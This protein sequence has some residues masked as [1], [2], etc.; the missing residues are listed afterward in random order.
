MLLE[1][2]VLCLFIGIIQRMQQFHRQ[3][4]NQE[5]LD[6]DLVVCK[7]VVNGSFCTLRNVYVVS[8]CKKSLRVNCEHIC[9]GLFYIE[10]RRSFWTVY[11]C[12]HLQIILQIVV[13]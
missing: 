2:F 3:Q 6:M 12:C 8:I 13:N 4:T 5:Q 11:K 9:D 10:N 7:G 1:F